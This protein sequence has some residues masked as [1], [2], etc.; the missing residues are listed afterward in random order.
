[1]KLHNFS[2]WKTNKNLRK[3]TPDRPSVLSLTASS[4]FGITVPKRENCTN[5]LKPLSLKHF[6]DTYFLSPAKGV[7]CQNRLPALNSKYEHEWL[8]CL[9]DKAFALSVQFSRFGTVMPVT[10]AKNG[11]TLTFQALKKLCTLTQSDRI[12]H[13][14][15]SRNPII[16]PQLRRC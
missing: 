14:F 4:V 16:N 15:N 3:L 8:R 11:F 9:L 12:K 5:R 2:Y 13:S 1:M 6:S 10:T 7:S